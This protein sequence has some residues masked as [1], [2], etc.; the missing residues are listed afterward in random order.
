MIG[1]PRIDIDTQHR[2]VFCFASESL[3]DP[4]VAD[5]SDK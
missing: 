4:V 1:A 3:V 2:C 5:G